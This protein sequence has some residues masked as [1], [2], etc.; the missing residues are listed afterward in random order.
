MANENQT[1]INTYQTNGIDGVKILF[2]LDKNSNIVF[3][4]YGDFNNTENSRIINNILGK[5]A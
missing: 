5:V 1:L 2:G 4:C 3:Q